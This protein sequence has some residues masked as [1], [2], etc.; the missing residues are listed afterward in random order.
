MARFLTDTDYDAQIRTDLRTIL[1]QDDDTILR[2][3]E[4]TAIDTIRQ[5]IG[6]RIDMD[7]ILSATGDDRSAFMV[8][9]I[10]DIAIYHLY[11]RQAPN[12][13]AQTRVDRYAY[14]MD[15]LSKASHGQVS[16]ALPLVERGSSPTSAADSDMRLTSTPVDTTRW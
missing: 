14:A 5:H 15:W 3:A 8:Q 11:A 2:Y 12:Q 10:I 13:I 7:K 16:H 9:I 4:N 6:G 1:T